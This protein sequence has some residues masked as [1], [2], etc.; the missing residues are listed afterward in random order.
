MMSVCRGFRRGCGCVLEERHPRADNRGRLHPSFQAL[1]AAPAGPRPQEVGEWTSNWDP[2]VIGARGQALP[3]SCLEMLLSLPRFHTQVSPLGTRVACLPLLASSQAW[4]RPLDGHA[5][6][7]PLP[8]KFP[9]GDSEGLSGAHRSAWHP[10]CAPCPAV[11]SFPQPHTDKMC[12]QPHRG[13]NPGS[14]RIYTHTA[15]TVLTDACDQGAAPSNAHRQPALA[16]AFA[17]HKT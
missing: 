3:A 14:R 7:P 6:A 4:A 10:T 1:V 8:G 16:A 17:G 12:P 15:T 2:L 5:L 13:R 11:S 9:P